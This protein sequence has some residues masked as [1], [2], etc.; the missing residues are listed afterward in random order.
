[1]DHLEIIKQRYDNK[2]NTSSEISGEDSFNLYISK[3]LN[4]NDIYN[5]KILELG[6]GGSVYIDFFLKN[7]CMNYYV[8]D[9]VLQ[10]LKMNSC[11]DLRYKEFL[12]DFIE[13]E[14]NE[15]VDIVMSN[16]TIMFLV[17]L[18][19]DAIK[20]INRFLKIDGIFINMDPN[21][22]CPLSIYRLYADKKGSNPARFFNPLSFAQKFRDN[23]F[24]VE[25]LI[26]Y[27]AKY[28]FTTGNWLLGTSFSMRARKIKNV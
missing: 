28:P 11:S 18:F 15:K 6:G 17:P 27:T 1:M 26:P 4:K 8:N 19:D 7:N 3:V 14:M 10:R 21:Y 22:L 24:E 20:A 2:N 23:G 16:L 25:L 12:G 13:L 5:K 9:L